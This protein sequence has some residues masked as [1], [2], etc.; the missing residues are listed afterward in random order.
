[1]FV[2][3]YFSHYRFF[4]LQTF[5]LSNP[6]PLSK[7]NLI[8]TD[9]DWR[10]VSTDEAKHEFNAVALQNCGKQLSAMCFVLNRERSLLHKVGLAQLLCQIP[11]CASNNRT[12]S[13]PFRVL[14]VIAK[15]K[16]QTNKLK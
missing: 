7:T 4:F 10:H 11:T 2:S 5:F 15:R 3:L 8:A 12:T 9:K 13:N 1:M 6:T 14:C 16:Q